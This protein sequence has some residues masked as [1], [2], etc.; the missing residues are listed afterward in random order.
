M[1]KKH[2]EHRNAVEESPIDLNL[3]PD[4]QTKKVVEDLINRHAFH[5]GLALDLNKKYKKWGPIFLV[6]IPVYSA[7]LSFLTSVFNGSKLTLGGL[8]LILTIA[9]ILNSILKP[10]EKFVAS[11]FV[12]VRLKDWEA[13]FA[14][15]LGEI[16]QTKDY[17]QLKTFLIRKNAELSEI[18]SSMA[19]TYLP[20]KNA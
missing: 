15:T 20:Q 4:E 12:L 19:R 18:G 6:L 16:A 13:D 10:D 8:A 7:I 14:L 1:A 3:M 9:T 5:T 17:K 11:S 2:V